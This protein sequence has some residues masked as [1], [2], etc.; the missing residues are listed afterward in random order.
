MTPTTIWTPTTGNGEMGIG[1]EN[2]ITTVSGLSLIT[3]SGKLIVTSESVFNKI[4]S[5]I[6]EEDNSI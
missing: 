2:D 5:T 4:P 3:V 1:P 6:W